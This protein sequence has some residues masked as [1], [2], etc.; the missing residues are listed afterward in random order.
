MTDEGPEMPGIK[1]YPFHLT[2]AFGGASPQGEALVR[3][4]WIINNGGAL[5]QRLHRVVSGQYTQSNRE[6]YSGAGF[7][8]CA[9]LIRFDTDAQTIK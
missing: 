2:T 1:R 3:R 9:D 5:N 8:P 4:W 7:R 6:A